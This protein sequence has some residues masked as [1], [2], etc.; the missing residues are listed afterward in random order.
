MW[1]APGPCRAKCL[2]RGCPGAP[3]S[4]GPREEP[5]ACSVYGEDGEHPD[6]TETT[7]YMMAGRRV[8][9]RGQLEDLEPESRAE[10]EPESQE[11]KRTREGSPG[12]KALA[13]GPA[14]NGTALVPTREEPLGVGAAAPVPCP[15]GHTPLRIC[16]L[17]P[18]SGSTAPPHSGPLLLTRV[19]A[20]T[21]EWLSCL[22]SSSLQIHFHPQLQHRAIGSKRQPEAMGHH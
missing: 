8:P 15:P 17:T 4:S 6:Q 18:L 22:R 5:R 2:S 1:T 7:S 13:G 20:A 19:P 10:G 14:R 12:Q 9:R 16:L 21:S 11:T 3:V